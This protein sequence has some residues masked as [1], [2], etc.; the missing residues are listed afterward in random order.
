MNFT[1]LDIVYALLFALR[2]TVVLSIA[3]F[4]LGGIVGLTIMWIRISRNVVANRL[5]KLYIELFQGTPLLMQLFMIFFGLALF[6]FEVNAWV[7]ALFG[8]VFWS[9]AFLSEIWRGCVESIHRG[10]WEASACLAMN[11]MQQMRYVVLPQALRVAIP[12]TV[13]FL[14]QIVKGTAVTSII[15]FVEVTK[16][17]S[18]IT[19]AT[20]KPF[21]VFGLVAVMYFLLCWPLSLYSRSLEKKLHVSHQH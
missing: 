3:G 16:A 5:A 6:G 2:W 18:I 7:A 12:P 9:S 19:N 11:R 17:G 13:G 14:V 10:Q 1:F 8:L 4:V 20:F 21:E 15:G